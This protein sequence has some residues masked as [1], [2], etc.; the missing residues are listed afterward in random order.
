MV[1]DARGGVVATIA[2]M[3]VIVGTTSR[4]SSAP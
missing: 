1:Y 2:T 3:G 4:C